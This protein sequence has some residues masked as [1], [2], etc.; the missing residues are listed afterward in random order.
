MSSVR[1]DTCAMDQLGHLFPHG[2]VIVNPA[3]DQV[4]TTFTFILFTYTYFLLSSQFR[5]CSTLTL[6]IALKA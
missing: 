1:D 5:S 4:L 6:T 3:N 2:A